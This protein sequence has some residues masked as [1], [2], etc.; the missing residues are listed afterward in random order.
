MN[1][2]VAMAGLGARFRDAG[3]TA[4]KPLIDVL[5]EPMYSWALKGLPLDLA[6]RVILIVSEELNRDPGFHKDL[7]ERYSNLPLVVRSTPPTEGQAC[8]VLLARDLIDNDEPLLIFNA[9]TYQQSSQ[10][11]DLIC[12]PHVDGSLSVFRAP[13]DKWSFV[14]TESTG[15]VVETAEK[16]RIS[17]WASTGLYHFAHGKDFVRAADEMIAADDRVN[18]EF[19][20]APVYNRLLKN[21][22]NIRLNEVEE[23]HVFGTPEDLNQFMVDHGSLEGDT[24]W[25]I[26]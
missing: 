13:G 12:N 23:I 5:G 4:P 16:R 26:R 22:A 14:R 6:D 17:E 10:L 19:Y 8:T 1:I 24:R 11:R 25:V 7:H 20:V 15:R 18:G 3:W 21:G 9:D 2:V